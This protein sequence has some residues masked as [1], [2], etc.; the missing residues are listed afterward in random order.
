[1]QPQ[2][3]NLESIPRTTVFFFLPKDQSIQFTM[4]QGFLSER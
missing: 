4:F 1:M 2:V 3:D